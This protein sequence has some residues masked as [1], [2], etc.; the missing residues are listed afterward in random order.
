M[1]QEM[2]VKNK[3][4]W[5][6]APGDSCQVDAVVNLVLGVR[7]MLSFGSLKSRGRQLRQHRPRLCWV[8]SNSQCTASLWNIRLYHDAISFFDKDCIECIHVVAQ[9]SVLPG[10]PRIR[11]IKL[12]PLELEKRNIKIIISDHL[13]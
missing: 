4:T 12:S 7:F 5:R 1:G 11:C 6:G 13:K 2:G 8:D 9:T 3:A 10:A